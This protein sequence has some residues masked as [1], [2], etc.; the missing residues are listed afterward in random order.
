MV[1][2]EKCACIIHKAASFS[3]KTPLTKEEFSE[4]HFF[5]LGCLKQHL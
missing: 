1:T 4:K 2:A 3:K 5:K